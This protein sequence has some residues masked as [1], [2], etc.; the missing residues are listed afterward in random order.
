MSANIFGL[1]LTVAALSLA[2][3]LLIIYYSKNTFN[4]ARTKL[5]KI[6]MWSLIIGCLIQIARVILINIGA[7]NQILEII[8]R[9]DF[10]IMGIWWYQLEIYTVLS[11]QKEMPDRVID[12]IKLNW[13]T[14]VLTIYYIIAFFTLLLAPFLSTTNEI[15]ANNIIYMPTKIIIT[16]I[17]VVVIEAF[18]AIY[19]LIK[20]KNDDYFKEERIVS[21]ETIFAVIIYFAI[22]SSFQNISFTHL[23]F[24]LFFYLTYFII[25]NPD[26][27]LL[28]EINISRVAIETSNKTK[29][30]FLANISNGIKPPID[31][32]INLCNESN[33]T[34]VY[35]PNES[36]ERVDEILKKGNELISVINNVLDASKIESGDIV[37]TEIQYNTLDL[38]DGL[39]NATKKRI[40]DKNIRIM[41]GIDKNV[42]SKLYGDYTKI[43]QSLVKIISNAAKFTEVG[44]ITIELASVKEGEIEHLSF[45]ITDTGIG[46]KDEEKDTV[47]N[48][49][50]NLSDDSTLSEGLGLGLVITKKYIESM[51]GKIWFESRYR[52]GTT[53]YI[54][55]DQ[56]IIDPTPIGD[57]SKRNYNEKVNI[58]DCSRFRALIVDDNL[59]NIKVAERLLKK[60]N[61][62]VDYVTNGQ[63]CIN[64]IKNF[65]KYDIIFIDDV[66][67]ELDGIGLLHIL[68]SLQGYDMPPLI[69]LTAN[70]ISGMKEIYIKEGFDDYLPKPINIYEFDKVINKY[71]NK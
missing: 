58:F 31:S 62:S 6:M 43:F 44:R 5:F 66:M 8:S 61:F 26:L 57:I 36:K 69:A 29:T 42:S 28:K 22:Q 12:V 4:N 35:N 47:F 39:I 53:F 60:Y 9:V 56:K 55:L 16:S 18:E 38:I 23:L 50:E 52:T 21:I 67:S 7:S 32:I 34:Q 17:F 71:F 41:M 51:G 19:Y 25:E 11:Y 70:A 68:R 3:L 20:Y 48:R 15:N 10:A 2:V 59:L 65:E 49:N 46:I 54:D 64:K 33:I 24:A 30:N 1:F 27:K 37:V 14:K 45:A 13:F 63:E 40:E